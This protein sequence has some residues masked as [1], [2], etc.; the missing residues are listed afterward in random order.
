[1]KLTKKEIKE[2]DRL[3]T[4]FLGFPV[5]RESVYAEDTYSQHYY[6][7]WVA[8]KSEE[9]FFVDDR[10]TN[11]TV[12]VVKTKHVGKAC[13]PQ[14]ANK[15]TEF[16]IST[17]GASFHN[18]WNMLAAVFG[19]ISSCYHE[20]FPIN[21]TLHFN[22]G[23]YISINKSNCAGQEYVGSRVIADTLNINYNAVKEKEKYS[24][25]ESVYIAV[26]KFIKWFNEQKK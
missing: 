4:A 15:K 14:D 7:N 26:I 19:K 20:G 5:F 2:G 1:M 3:I 17:E 25:I 13:F 18:D 12:A 6:F 24:H 8:S 21:G 16:I 11:K 23:A 10:Y 22:G 9:I